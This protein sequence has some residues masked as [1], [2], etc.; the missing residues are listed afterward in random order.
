MPRAG[1]RAKLLEWIRRYG[2]AEIVGIACAFLAVFIVRAMT[3]SVVAIGYAG[4]CGETLGYV[5][6]IAARDFLTAHRH[7]VRAGGT[8]GVRQSG[9]VVLDMLGEFGPAAVLDTF[10]I[11]PLAMAAGVRFLGTAIGLIVG[12]IVGDIGFYVPV[13]LTYEWRRRRHGRTQ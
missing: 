11:R 12:K 7:A 8:L 5:G 2:V 4:A 13:I 3:A 10:L 9:G 1:L 6:A